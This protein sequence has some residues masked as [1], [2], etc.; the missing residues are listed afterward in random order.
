MSTGKKLDSGAS[1]GARRATGDAPE[2]KAR[3]TGSA[4]IRHTISRKIGSR[5][6]S[7]GR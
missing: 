4:S 2:S 5:E 7:S 3:G 6:S 1:E